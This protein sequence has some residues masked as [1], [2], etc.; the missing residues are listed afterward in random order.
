MLMSFPS[1]LMVPPQPMINVE[2]SSSVLISDDQ[3]LDGFE[4]RYGTRGGCKSGQYDYR[5]PASS[6]L[7]VNLL[8]IWLLQE[9][10]IR[11]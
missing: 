8:V 2:A 11:M 4:V 9:F 10:Y 3:D 1:S 5:G 7:K 6:S